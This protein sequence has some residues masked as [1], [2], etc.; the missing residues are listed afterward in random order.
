ME[1]LGIE[2]KLLLAQIINF[3][4]IIFVLSKLLYKPILAMLEKRKKEIEK[5][6]ALSQRMQEE[7]VKLKQKQEKM[8]DETRKQARMILEEAK[9]QG[10]E[11]EREIVNEAHKEAKEIVEKGRLELAHL[12]KEMEKDLRKES[13]ALA[14]AMA[15]RLLV[16]VMKEDKQHQLLESQ[17]KELESMKE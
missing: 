14:T 6:L 16:S 9:K 13:V 11:A 2:P 4:I 5:G 7:E 1:Q 15:K 8:L 3:S 17:L 12:H 10:K